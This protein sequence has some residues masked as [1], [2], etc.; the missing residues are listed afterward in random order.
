MS[1][2]TLHMARKCELEL[3]QM[4]QRLG[5][6]LHWKPKAPMVFILRG[7]VEGELFLFATDG[8]ALRVQRIRLFR[9]QE[10]LWAWQDTHGAGPLSALA[11][12]VEFP[13]GEEGDLDFS[14]LASLLPLQ[15]QGEVR[16]CDARR[17][18]FKDWEST[19][20]PAD[21]EGVGVPSILKMGASHIRPFPE[22]FQSWLFAFGPSVMI[23]FCATFPAELLPSL[24]FIPEAQLDTQNPQLGTTWAKYWAFN[25]SS[26]EPL[27]VVMGVRSRDLVEK[28]VPKKGP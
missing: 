14:S 11:A 25:A 15:L 9:S 28:I 26:L 6:N 20:G 21:L 2:I 3:V 13:E 1:K 17:G 27:G 16:V 19:W 10:A 23:S 18:P 8:L 7:P 5:A 22:S 12:W 24:V 4:L